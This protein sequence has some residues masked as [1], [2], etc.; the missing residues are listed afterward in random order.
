MYI[1]ERVSIRIAD[2]I[3]I[4]TIFGLKYPCFVDVANI[5][6]PLK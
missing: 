2:E 4:D 6:E 3:S 1:Y 5:R